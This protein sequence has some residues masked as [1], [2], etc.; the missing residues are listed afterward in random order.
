MS[1]PSLGLEFPSRCT[2]KLWI[3]LPPRCLPKICH[4]VNV[5]HSFPVDFIIWLSRRES[6]CVFRTRIPSLK[7]HLPWSLGW[8]SHIMV[9]FCGRKEPRKQDSKWSVLVC[10]CATISQAL[11]MGI[12]QDYGVFLPVI[13][14]EFYSSREHTGIGLAFIYSDWRGHHVV[15]VYVFVNLNEFDGDL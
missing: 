2:A 12:A 15:Y 1:S 3:P 5:W 11:L 7:K 4:A 6:V 13:M 10:I 8:R 14:N 9:T